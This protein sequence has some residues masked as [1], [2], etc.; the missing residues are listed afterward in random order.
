MLPACHGI[1]GASN[2]GDASIDGS[3]IDAAGAADDAATGGDLGSAG[4]VGNASADLGAPCTTRITYGDAWIH[5]AQHP[6]SFDVAAGAVTWDGACHDDG[7]NSYALLSNGWK[8]YFSGHGACVMALDQASCASAPKACATRVTYGAAWLPP[9]GHPAQY[10]DV[11]GRVTWDRACTASGAQ[12]YASL[13]NGWAPH[14]DGSAACNLSLAY[15]QCGGLY[16]NAVLPAGCADPGVVRDG[17]RYVLSCTSGNAAD[18]FPI[19]VSTDL[20]HW[21][22]QGHIFPSGKKPAW[23]A[24]DFW[25][26]EIHRVGSGWVA[27]FTARHTDGKLCI[28]AA[29]AASA[30]G[31]F[32]D[33][34]QPLLHDTSMGL[35][36][37][38]ELET[39]DGKRYLYWKEDGNAVGKP[40][41]I[42]G[43]QL[44]ADGLSLVGARADIIT[45]DR[46]WEG[47]VVEGPWLVA[48]GG[49]YYLFYSGNSYANATY[50]VGVA[51]AAAPLGPFTKA[52]APIVTSN[53]AWV[54]PGHCSVVDGP[55]GDPYMV[56]HAWVAGHVNQPGDVRVMLVDRLVWGADGWPSLPG[57]PSTSSRPMP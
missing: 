28:G 29:T 8:P 24:S 25:A 17:S 48:H 21:T 52:A 15:T 34:G 16:E 46:A 5:G 31:P 27:Y 2:D 33:L 32:V 40:T 13:S 20:V 44:A 7:A 38:T 57:G 30:L 49:S 18:A 11:A 3:P 56:Y 45:N 54:G 51:R 55:G 37:A 10:D 9:A 43:Q 50:A 4:G 47:A 19:R 42:H 1:H 23:A 53:S 36:D 41:P 26:P 39:A 12:S 22:A 14:F 6:A 35:I